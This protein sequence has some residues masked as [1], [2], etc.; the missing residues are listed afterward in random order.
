MAAQMGRKLIQWDFRDTE[1]PV[2]TAGIGGG[3]ILYPI[4]GRPG[5]ACPLFNRN[6][7][8][9][10]QGKNNANKRK[11]KTHRRK[12]LFLIRRSFAPA[13]DRPEWACDR[14]GAGLGQWS[15]GQAE[16]GADL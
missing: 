10:N 11:P 3:R 6:A 14:S 7:G 1:A 9:Q 12:T 2:G 8:P 5:R 15:R 16:L 4:G 13:S